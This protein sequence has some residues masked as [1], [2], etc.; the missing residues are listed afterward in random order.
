MSLPFFFFFFHFRRNK[1]QEG[2]GWSSCVTVAGTVTRTIAVLPFLRETNLKKTKPKIRVGTRPV[3]IDLFGYVRLH[4][5]HPLSAIVPRVPLASN[6]HTST[7]DIRNFHSVLFVLFCFSF[8]AC[9]HKNKTKAKWII[10]NLPTIDLR[11][12]HNSKKHGN[13]VRLV[14]FDC[15]LF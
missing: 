8:S 11:M 13:K 6:C 2:G 12:E 15:Y 10:E 5:A 3:A 14:M 9:V 1:S 4:T 7:R